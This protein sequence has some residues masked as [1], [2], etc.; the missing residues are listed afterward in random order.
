M[1]TNCYVEYRTQIKTADF[2]YY[3]G[4]RTMKIKFSKILEINLDFSPDRMTQALEK[5]GK[6]SMTPPISKNYW[7][8]RIKLTKKQS[9]LA[10]PKFGTIGIGFAREKD[11]N[12][13]LPYTCGAEQIYKHIKYNKLDAKKRD[14]VIA[15]E[16]IQKFCENLNI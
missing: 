6:I 12:R 8:Y 5:I 2:K 4:G 16:S 14:C 3:Y 1:R 10:F 13:N 11:W 15:I 7:L 9:I